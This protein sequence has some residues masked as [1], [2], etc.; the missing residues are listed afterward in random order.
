[1]QEERVSE[2][3]LVQIWSRFGRGML[4]SNEGRQMEVIYPGSRNGGRGPDFL[5]AII[6]AENEELIK[7]DIELHLR[8]SDWRAHGHHYDP[9][10]NGVILHIV[11]YG[12]ETAVTLQNGKEVPTLALSPRLS[13][14]E[15][16]YRLSQRPE[17]CYHA[18]ERSGTAL[19]RLLDEAGEERLRLKAASFH[20]MLRRGEAEQAL[21]QGIMRALGYA[22]NKEQFHKLA[23]SLPLSTIHDL[24]RGVGEEERLPML[25]A[26]LLGMAGLLPSQR[27]IG[28]DGGAAELE[29]LWH[30]LGAEAVMSHAEWHLV[31]VRPGNFP[32]RRLAAASYFLNRFW[33]RGLLQSVLELVRKGRKGLEAGFMVTAEGYWRWHFD[34]GRSARDAALIGRGR[35]QEIVVNVALPFALAWAQLGSQPELERRALELYRCYP[36]LGE[37]EITRSMSELLWGEHG[38]EVISSAQRQQGLLHLSHSFCREGKCAQCPL[39]PLIPPG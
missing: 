32:P 22:K 1:M 21:Y 28:L 39:I 30:C 38:A 33:G 14:N 4:F 35:A 13:L 3:L 19:G 6:V 17:P 2:N 24:V 25:Q 18:V 20:E 36:K 29:R 34:F 10:Y 37:N 12:E 5:D 11:W 7:G 16:R 27:G 9:W 31:W 26:L 8:A 23:S 15:V